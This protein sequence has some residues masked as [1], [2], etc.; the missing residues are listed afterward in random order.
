M[1]TRPR[2]L[3]MPQ[4]TLLCFVGSCVASRAA[5]CYGQQLGVAI[6]VGNQQCVVLSER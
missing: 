6:T 1:P 2:S 3:L 5:R 4:V